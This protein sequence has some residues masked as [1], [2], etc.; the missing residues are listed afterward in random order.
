MTSKIKCDVDY[1]KKINKSFNQFYKK[2]DVEIYYLDKENTDQNIM[3]DA[4]NFSKIPI[5]IADSYFEQNKSN[6]TSELSQIIF[7]RKQEVNIIYYFNFDK[8]IKIKLINLL[9]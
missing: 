5:D 6:F 9:F 1:H 7:D 2:N 4:I 8:K 3:K